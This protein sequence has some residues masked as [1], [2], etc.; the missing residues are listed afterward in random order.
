LDLLVIKE[1]GRL[2]FPPPPG[3]REIFCEKAKRL[4]R[5]P[6]HLDS[7]EQLFSQSCPLSGKCLVLRCQEG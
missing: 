7:I 1:V 2:P 3:R 6:L 4:L 5:F